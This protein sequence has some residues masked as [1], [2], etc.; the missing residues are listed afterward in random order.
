MSHIVVITSGLTGILNA[1]FELMHRLEK[2]GYRV[3]C[4]CPQSIGEKVKKQG[5]TYFQLQAVNFN[6][7][8]DVPY[9]R[10]NFGKVKGLFYKWINRKE[11]KKKAIAALKMQDFVL[12]LQELK[13]DLLILD[14]ELHEH[15]MTAIVKKYPVL[16]LSQWFS[17]W[18]R[19]GLPPLLQDTIPG[20]GERG[21]K[22]A[23]S[24]AWD[25]IEQ[26]RRRTFRRQKL[27][28][29]GTDRRSILQAYVAQIGFPKEYIPD[30]YWPGPFTYAKLPVIS[31]TTAELEFPHELRPNLTYVGAM[32][33]AERK[34][35]KI[36]EK[37]DAQLTKIFQQKQ[38]TGAALIYCSVSTFKEGDTDFL[39][40]LAAAID[41]DKRYIL[42]IGLGGMLEQDI[43]PNPS[44]NVHCFK[45]IPQ[46]K[47]LAEADLSINHGGIHTI[48][49]CLHFRVPMLIYS[50]KRSDQNGCAARVHYHKIGIMADK[51][52]DSPEEIKNKI[53]TVLNESIYQENIEKFS[54][55]TEDYKEQKTMEK[56]VSQFIKKNRNIC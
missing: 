19:E 45:W 17:L 4:A 9:F 33:F 31:M 41:K 48:N 29:A 18:R 51:D 10:G 53:E 1:S 26:E 47:V 52:K 15:I 28:S 44:K 8:P 32:V 56:L 22:E 43:L 27:R 12:N 30:N 35:L 3:T 55:I 34:D 49:E 37:V 46:L 36:D 39:Q 24:A 50:G 21:T 42:I 25:K 7:A 40:K 23:I 20:V 6:P 16:L 5:F 14:V 13:P 2:A 11:R 54:K 38:K